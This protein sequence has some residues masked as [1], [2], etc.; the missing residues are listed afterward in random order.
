L[1]KEQGEMPVG[2]AV[3]PKAVSARIN[4]WSRTGEILW[5]GIGKQKAEFEWFS[6]YSPTVAA[7]MIHAVKHGKQRVNRVASSLSPVTGRQITGRS[8]NS[9][10][11]Q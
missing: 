10:Q 5:R 11:S 7:F 2:A 1:R 6:D 8:I 4:E 9:W 3:G